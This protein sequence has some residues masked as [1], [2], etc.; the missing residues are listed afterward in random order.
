ML[1]FIVG[2]FAVFL[3]GIAFWINSDIQDYYKSEYK[4]G[5]WSTY[6]MRLWLGFYALINPVKVFKKEKLKIGHTRIFIE[7]SC[8]LIALMLIALALKYQ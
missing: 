8:F 2:L 3:L 6:K 1:V 4:R 7:I 5:F